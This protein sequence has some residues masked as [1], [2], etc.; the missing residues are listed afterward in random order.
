MALSDSINSMVYMRDTGYFSTGATDTGFAA[1]FAAP[2]LGFLAKG[3]LYPLI[4][5]EFAYA[6][7]ELG[8]CG[9]KTGAICMLNAFP[10]K[11]AGA[12]ELLEV[13]APVVFGLNTGASTLKTFKSVDCATDCV[14]N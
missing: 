12:P 2:L 3:F 14:N 5:S 11:E 8:C 13:D 10:F 4:G 7:N 6:K 9:M 1:T